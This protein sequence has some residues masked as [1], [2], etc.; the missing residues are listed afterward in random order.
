M[1]MKAMIIH[2]A[3]DIRLEEK[4]KPVPGPY[5]VVSKVSYSGIC[6]TDLGIFNGKVSFAKDGGVKYPL[7]VGHEWSG[8]VDS[9][10]SAVT[11]FKPGDRVVSDTGVSC[12]K[13]ADCLAG[14]FNKCKYGKSLGTLNAHE[15][16]TFAEYIMIPEW[17]MYHL[18]GRVSLEQGALIEPAVIALTGIQTAGIKATGIQAAGDRLTNDNSNQACGSAL[19]IGTG[20]IGLACVA[21]LKALGVKKVFVAGRK[22]GK[23]N[24][25]LKLG[26]DIA[27][28]TVSGPAG[29][30]M[31][32]AIMKETGGEGANIIL[33]ASGSCGMLDQALDCAA[34]GAIINLIG[35]YEDKFSADFNL[36]RIV[37]KSLTINGSIPSNLIQTVMGMM[38]AGTID[39]SELITHTIPIEE[40]AGAFINS[41]A[42]SADKIK[43]LVKM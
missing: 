41:A 17:N 9:V 27:I 42:M 16:G 35:F 36:D 34:S 12:G 40:C 39:L 25:G 15:Y 10:G 43:V 28:N 30:K 19:V 8:I 24:A 14:N 23:L 3:G 1:K 38:A 20:A 7:S 22:Q 37:L 29:E 18:D 32:D 31:A 13:C 5:D 2:G 26:A 21:F 4:D 11:K 6:G 33:E